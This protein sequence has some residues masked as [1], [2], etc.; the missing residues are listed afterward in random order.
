MPECFDSCFWRKKEIWV[1]RY[2]DDLWFV[3]TTKGSTLISWAL[4]VRT[5]VYTTEDN[6]SYTRFCHSFWISLETIPRPLF[7]LNLDFGIRNRCLCK[8]F[9][10]VLVQGSYPG[11]GTFQCIRF[12]CF[13]NLSTYITEFIVAATV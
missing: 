11:V 7:S 4:S 9:F 13:R 12:Q 1:K 10:S 8:C 5:E 3:Q 2:T 6:R